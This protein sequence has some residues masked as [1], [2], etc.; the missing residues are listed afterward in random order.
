M[1]A[2]DLGMLTSD[3][4]ET[5]KN[6]MLLFSKQIMIQG[7]C[8][9]KYPSFLKRRIAGPKGHLSNEEAA[10]G[11]LE[12]IGERTKTVILAHLSQENNLPSLARKTIEQIFKETK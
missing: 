5:L 10:K 3:I 12:L 6:P 2:T 4:I 8:Y 9:G 11:L 1:G 7:C